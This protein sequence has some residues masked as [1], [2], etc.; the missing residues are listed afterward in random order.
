MLGLKIEIE[1]LLVLNKV[2]LGHGIVVSCFRVKDW[3][4]ELRIPCTLG[5]GV[6]VA[7]LRKH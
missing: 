5:V 4:R 6:K 7:S 1:I 2:C 3:A